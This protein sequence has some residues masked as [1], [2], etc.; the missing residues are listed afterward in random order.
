M[1]NAKVSSEEEI[2]TGIER[3]E[4]VKKGVLIHVPRG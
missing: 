1:S 2:R 4:F 3:A